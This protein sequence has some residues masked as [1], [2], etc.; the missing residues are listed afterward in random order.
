MIKMTW[1]K[2]LKLILL[3]AVAFGPLNTYANFDIGGDPTVSSAFFDFQACSSYDTIGT[4]RDYSEF[5]AVVNSN[6]ACSQ[7]EI[8]GGFL[9]RNNPEVNWHSCTEGFDGQLA[10][11]VSSD[12]SCTYN[13]GDEKSV[14]IDVS[15]M[16]GSNGIGN[17]SG[18][19]FYEA[20]PDTFDWFDGPSGGNNYPTLYGIRILKNGA[21]I[22]RQA[23]IPTTQNW[24]LET[25]DFSNNPDFQVNVPTIFKIELLGYCQIGNGEMVTAWDID[26]LT[27]TSTCGVN[28]PDA[29]FTSRLIECT[30]NGFLV[31][32]TNTTQGFTATE[33]DW[34]IN[35]NGVIA[36]L[37]GSPIVIETNG[38]NLNVTMNGLF[39]NRCE[40]SVT[41]EV[42]VSEFLPSLSITNN[43]ATMDCIS[44]TEADITFSAL[45]TGG[46]IAG[47]ITSY[48]WLIDG[49]SSTGSSTTVMFQEGQNSNIQLTVNYDNGCSLVSTQNFTANFQPTLI[50]SEAINCDN[51]NTTLVLSDDTVLGGGVT[52]TT[53][54]WIVDGVV[55]SN[56]QSISLNLGQADVQVVLEVVF[57]NG[58]TGRYSK[59]FNKEDFA[60]TPAIVTS[61]IDCDGEIANVLI[62]GSTTSPI[63][64]VG[65][66]WVVNGMTF[67]SSPI[68]I[69]VALDASLS[70]N[71][72]VEYSN[73]CTA[74]NS[75]NYST[76]GDIL[77]TPQFTAAFV[78]CGDDGFVFTL[79]NTT[80]ST[81]PNTISWVVND[82]GVETTY[83]GDPVNILVVNEEFTATL[84]VDYQNGCSLSTTNMYNVNDFPI[85]VGTPTLDYTVEAVECIGANGL[86]TFTDN[87]TAGNC[88][89]IVSIEW[90]ING[91]TYTGSPITIELPLGE[92][93]D[94]VHTVTF[95]D[96]TVLSTST[97]TNT[98]NDVINTNNIVTN[99][100]IEIANNSLN[101]C[102]DALD[103]SV[104]NPMAG[105]DYEWSTDPEFSNII[106]TGIDL[107]WI[108]N[109]NFTGTIYV[110]STDNI[111]PCLYGIG[112]ITIDNNAISLSFDMPFIICPGDTATYTVVNNNP[113]QTIT[114]DWKDPEGYVVAGGDTNM[115]TIG[116]SENQTEDFFLV[117]CTENN[118]GCT[119]VD[120]INFGIG[121]PDAL[122][123]FTFSIED[124]GDLTVMF[125]EAPNDLMGNG[126]WD[127]GDGMGT[128]TESAPTYTYN[129]PGNYTVTLSSDADACGGA[130][131]S[132]DIF[133]G[134]IAIDITA[135]QDTIFYDVGESVTVDA[136]TNANPDDITWCT[137]DGTNIATGP[138][139]ENYEPEQD[140]VTVIAKV[141]DAFGCE[142][143]DTI[144]LIRITD[145][146]ECLETANLTGPEGG[147]ICEGDEFQLCVVFGDDC[148]AADF[149]FLWEDNGCIISTD[150]TGPKVT[151]TSTTD[152]T[153]NVQVTDIL[154]GLDTI[155][156]IDITISNPQVSISVPPD[157]IDQ[158]GQNFVCLGESV[159]LIA[160]GDP[161]CEYIWSTGETGT[162]IT[163]EPE[164]ETEY[165][166][167]CINELGCESSASIVS[168]IVVPP[169]CDENDVFIP[170]A[171]SPNG[172]MVNDVLFVRSKFIEDLV[173]HVQDRWGAEVFRT[174]TQTEGW[175]GTYKDEELPPDVYTYC[176]EV[177]CIDG[178]T[179]N[180]VGNVSILK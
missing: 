113:N 89:T 156:M 131:V 115:P 12:E 121:A 34:E 79:D 112:S 140:T 96:G 122:E 13:A 107:E 69:E 75:Q 83:S 38:T 86:F 144:V 4:N 11:C 163:V 148:D 168:V 124:C 20:A 135:S 104:S 114:Y 71:Y 147:E 128:S 66:S 167:I 1:I 76:V 27:I 126:V 129:E 82:G 24:T 28:D 118:F 154:S 105:L 67:T 56:D 74:S 170:N 106:G 141:V 110:Q 23:D 2:S 18:L 150:L 42:S 97:D 153:F 179:Y 91:E 98:T 132:E 178:A 60:T 176:I 145:M 49:V 14:V 77:G 25:F 15:V 65:E 50:V 137:L 158:T 177:T 55:F 44:G 136:T 8:L 62:V 52:A 92:D 123:P 43:M 162:S 149:A 39:D 133:V 64:V 99:F 101:D 51:N 58:C 180:K 134:D 155:L 143:Q 26:D 87:S 116:I 109:Q 37:T 146:R 85:G 164:V 111:G 175:D 7:L 100:P 108:I 47:N 3:L 68:N 45:I 103:L 5:T 30:D 40:A 35:D 36:N 29:T 59:I 10:M 95:S 102:G 78:S 152:K 32:L 73:G 161:D 54:T 173:F 53:R 33:I 120:T 6:P 93:I 171:F 17:L 139:L 22:F 117:L 48:E 31:E 57:S 63:G 119:S 84:T 174:T 172:D 94:F 130:M 157:N 16:P 142:D 151:A 80:N 88:L 19:S 70:I 41:R 72:T 81:L 90:I 166:V 125:N 165:S 169:T 159:T 160:V 21:E 138:T 127:F 46:N 9:Y 61:V